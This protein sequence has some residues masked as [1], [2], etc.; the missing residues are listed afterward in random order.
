[1]LLTSAQEAETRRILGTS[2]PVHRG[3]GWE[4]HSSSR[5]EAPAV[6]HLPGNCDKCVFAE[7]A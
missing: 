4:S 6:L 2:S 1:L 7:M 5:Q 3:W